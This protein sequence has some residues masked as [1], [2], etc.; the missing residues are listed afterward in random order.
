MA[1]F[2]LIFRFTR[3]LRLCA[4]LSLAYLSAVAESIEE[5]EVEMETFVPFPEGV[6]GAWEVAVLLALP[7]KSLLTAPVELLLEVVVFGSRA[8][9]PKHN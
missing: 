8:G 3:K 1:S 5:N 6:E 9:I 4:L 7:W 2:I